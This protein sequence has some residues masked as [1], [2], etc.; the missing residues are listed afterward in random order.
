MLKIIN[1]NELG[2]KELLNELVMEIPVS[3]IRSRR[4]S[5]TFPIIDGQERECIIKKM[6][7]KDYDFE[8]IPHWMLTRMKESIVKDFDEKDTRIW[9]DIMKGEFQK[10]TEAYIE[11]LEN[12]KEKEMANQSK[13]RIQ[14]LP[15]EV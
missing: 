4:Y 13:G 8:Q 10:N 3:V 6:W 14:I 7:D 15:K 1:K 12:S 2:I 9:N 11:E 5:F